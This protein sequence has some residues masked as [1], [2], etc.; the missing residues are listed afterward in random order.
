MWAQQ[1]VFLFNL[2]TPAYKAYWTHRFL[3]YYSF[4]FGVLICGAC[5]PLQIFQRCRNTETCSSSGDEFP[6][7]ALRGQILYEQQ[8]LQRSAA[9]V[10]LNA[11]P[12]AAVSHSEQVISVNRSKHM[13][14][15]RRFW[16][17]GWLTYQRR[18]HSRALTLSLLMCLPSTSNG[19]RA[20]LTNH[21]PNCTRA[22]STSCSLQP[23]A[24]HSRQKH[25]SDPPDITASWWLFP[26][27]VLSFSLLVKK[28]L[29]TIPASSFLL[30]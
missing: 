26:E 17:E 11:G 20:A 14:P 27:Q 28:N 9:A 5:N 15:E 2:E 8:L 29:S 16:E 30:L 13:W 25:A 4:N 19:W 3:V 12:A 24:A 10:V 23:A 7:A 18:C 22:E 1:C 21:I 6:A